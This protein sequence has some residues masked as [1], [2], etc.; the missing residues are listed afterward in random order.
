M[1]DE[2][3]PYAEV[4]ATRHDELPAGYRHVRRRVWLGA[5]E[6]VFTAVGSAVM[7]FGLQRRAGLRPVA[8]ADR[9][10]PGVVVTG[11]FGLG[12][13][14]F[15][16]PCRVVWAVEDEHSIGFGYGTLPGHPEIGEEAFVVRRDEGGDVWLTILAFSRPELW[17]VRLAGPVGHLMQ[18]LVTA[19]Y[20]RAA[21]AF[22]TSGR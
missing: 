20:V 5:G 21:R 3:L 2:A 6:S 10:A 16:L 1:S 9:A 19:R 22:A 18:D 12:P 7:A 15:P 11:R 14:S 8:T 4:G 13:L 17:L